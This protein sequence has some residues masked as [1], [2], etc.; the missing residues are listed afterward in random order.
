MVNGRKTLRTLIEMEDR[1]V[2]VDKHVHVHIL[3]RKAGDFRRNDSIYDEKGEKI[4]NNDGDD[5][6][7]DDDGDDDGDDDDDDGDDGGDDDD[8]EEEEEEDK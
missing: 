6:D 2:E 7:D 8:G 5:D 3:P 1:Y 4:N